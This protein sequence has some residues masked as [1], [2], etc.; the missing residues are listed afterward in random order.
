MEITIEIEDEHLDTFLALIKTFEGVEIVAIR[1]DDEE[2]VPYVEEPAV[3]Y[4]KKDRPT[5]DEIEQLII[6]KALRDAKAIERGEL[7]T[8]QFNSLEELLADLEA[9][10]T[11]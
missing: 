1:R 3:T 6:A 4:A 2:F 9:D 7:E 10:I 5:V 8:R 11:D